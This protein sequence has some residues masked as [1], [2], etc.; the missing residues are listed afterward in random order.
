MWIRWIASAVAV[1]LLAGCGNQATTES[2]TAAPQQTFKWKLVT[3]WPKNYPG[4]GM[5]PENFAKHV[6]AMSNGYPTGRHNN[7]GSAFAFS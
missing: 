3:T 6:K 2:A 7:G 1:L 4:L 5:A